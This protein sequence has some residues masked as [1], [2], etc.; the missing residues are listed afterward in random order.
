MSGCDGGNMQIFVAKLPVPA[1]YTGEKQL[2][3][4]QV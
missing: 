1:V 4:F 2:N 3:I